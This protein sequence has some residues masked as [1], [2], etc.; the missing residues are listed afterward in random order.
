MQS[1]LTKKKYLHL[2]FILLITLC[3]LSNA[4]DRFE[5]FE[6]SHGLSNNS[7]RYISQDNLGYLWISTMNG[8]NR[9]DGKKFKHYVN[10]PDDSTSIYSNRI[11]QIYTDQL[12]NNWFIGYD[13]HVNYFNRDKNIFTHTNFSVRRVKNT[14]SQQFIL[15]TSPGILWFNDAQGGIRKLISISGNKIS[16]EFTNFDNQLST[17]DVSIITEDSDGKIWVGTQKGLFMIPSD[18]IPLN[19][20]KVKQYW[21]N[22]EVSITAITESESEIWI[23]TDQFGIFIIDKANE[24]VST[25]PDNNIFKE[26]NI[27]N[28]SVNNYGEWVVATYDDGIYFF[29][30]HDLIHHFNNEEIGWNTTSYFE[31]YVDRSNNFWVQSRKNGVTLINQTNLIHFPLRKELRAS[32]EEDESLYFLEDHNDDLWIGTYGSG[33]FKYDSAKKEFK[34][35]A[36]EENNPSSISSNFILSLFQDNSHNLWIGT[37]NGGVNKLLL[38]KS[39]FKNYTPSPNSEIKLNSEVRALAEDEKH[40]IWIGTK[41]GEIQCLD[42]TFNLIATL[43]NNWLRDNSFDLAGIYHLFFDSEGNLWVSTKGNGLYIFPKVSQKSNNSLFK[44]LNIKH[45]HA[46]SKPALSSNYVYSVAEDEY[47]QI[48]VAT[49]LGGLNRLRYKNNKLEIDHFK[50]SSIS[51]NTITDNRAR[52]TLADSNGNLWVGTGNGLN[53]I[54]KDQLQEQNPSIIKINSE[55]NQKNNISYNDILYIHEDN[56]KQIWIGTFGGG[57]NKLI[58]FDQ[59]SNSLK[60]EHIDIDRQINDNTIYSVISDKEGQIWMATD[61]GI[62]KLDQRSKKIDNFFLSDVIGRNSFSEAGCLFT[63]NNQIIFGH[64]NGLVMFSPDS[65]KKDTQQFPLVIN[66]FY[67]YNELVKPGSDSPLPQAIENTTEIILD[68]DQNFIGFEFAVLDYRSPNKIS[69]FYKL[70]NYEDDWNESGNVNS[71]FYKNLKPGKYIFKVRNTNI[72]GLPNDTVKS[73]RIIIKKP[74]YATV[75]ALIIYI[76][77]AF[78]IILVIMYFA[79]KE[80]QMKAKVELE[81]QMTQNK[82]QFY[83]NISHEL[84]TPLALQLGAIEKIIKKTNPGSSYLLDLLQVKRNAHRLLNLIEQLIDFRKIQHKAYQLNYQNVNLLLFFEEIYEAFKPLAKHKKIQFQFIQK[85]LDSLAGIDQDSIERVIFN[86]LSNAFKN[87]KPNK[88]V[89]LKVEKVKK[90]IEIQV[91]DEGI[92]IPKENLNDIF[93]QFTSGNQ[94]NLMGESNSGIGLAFTKEIIK[95]MKGKI[96]IESEED[97]GTKFSILIPLMDASQEISNPHL[98]RRSQ[99]ELIHSELIKNINFEKQTSKPRTEKGRILIVD[100]HDE[101]REML[102]DQVASFYIVEEATNGQEAI[103]LLR[104]DNE[105]DLIVTD[106]IMPRIDGI[107]LTKKVRANAQTAHI[108]VILLTALTGEENNL[109]SIKAGVDDFI[110]KPYHPEILLNKIES[111]IK[112]RKILKQLFNTEKKPEES[113]QNKTETKDQFLEKISAKIENNIGQQDFNIDVLSEEL[114]IGRSV[115]YKKMKEYTG[116]TP[117]EYIKNIKMKK[118]AE[119][120]RTTDKNIN[121]VA[122][123]VG[124]NDIGYFR[125]CFKNQFGEAPRA[126]QQKFKEY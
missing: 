103:E 40:R 114:G 119:L 69:Y 92:G 79:S 85:H 55:S 81:R 102:K 26:L 19:S 124:Y 80:L 15:E 36:H 51:P 9:F 8:V 14:Q 105:F 62:C 43:E 112:Q 63:H 99:F 33:L 95:L 82:L 68:H 23:G 38:E 59:E 6:T 87:T 46:N 5:H 98:K 13:R 88:K 121:Q 3:K 28:I 32:V 41:T 125:K 10:H 24:I 11:L 78:G 50:N 61:Q 91:I 44:N 65:I 39:N 86:L 48:W 123:D 70:K 7:V 42:S 110:A 84:K 101:V 115:F 16:T 60:W 117:N 52:C 90:H 20:N 113:L 89:I 116:K 45:F 77:I 31:T 111:L 83:T 1:Q 72:S 37:R 30:G 54:K 35:F 58:A 109:E 76:S 94:N 97:K 64:T 53:L 107:E 100:D 22:K 73:I 104:N 34:H 120:L 126:Y 71:A 2:L 122:Y 67:L 93:N 57:L 56:S 75:L 4:Q 27:L 18:T 108:P 17:N 74:Y 106:F 49:Y 29:A 96:E 12:G 25:H 47:N 66:S 118:A 21:K